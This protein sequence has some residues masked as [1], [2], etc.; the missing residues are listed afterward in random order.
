[1]GETRLQATSNALREIVVQV[2]L[3]DSQGGLRVDSGRERQKFRYNES[4]IYGFHTYFGR[5]A[6]TG[7][8][9]MVSNGQMKTECDVSFPQTPMTNDVCR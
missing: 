1:M 2:L 7:L 8:F 4:W 9:E 6:E 5:E 3:G